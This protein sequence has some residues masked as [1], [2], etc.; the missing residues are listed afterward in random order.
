MATTDKLNHFYLCS[1][2]WQIWLIQLV[3]SALHQFLKWVH[4]AAA[5]AA[6]RSF[7][8]NAN[9]WALTQTDQR[10]S[11]GVAPGMCVS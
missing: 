6:L 8:T 9:S 10:G 1:T 7:D 11:L 3:F 2:T 5:A 4:E